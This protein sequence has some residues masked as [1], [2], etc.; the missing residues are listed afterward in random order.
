VEGGDFYGAKATINVWDPK[1]QQPNE[2]SLSQI[3]ILAGAF[4]QDLNSIEAGWQVLFKFLAIVIFCLTRLVNS[5]RLRLNQSQVPE[6]Q[7]WPK[8]SLTILFLSP[9]RSSFPLRT[10][11]SEAKLVCLKNNFQIKFI[12]F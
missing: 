11:L 10:G 2:F 5:L 8:Q 7:P 9:N 12:I 6:F 3:W 4:G 1:I